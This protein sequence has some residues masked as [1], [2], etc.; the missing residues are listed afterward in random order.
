[1]DSVPNDL[2]VTTPAPKNFQCACNL[3]CRKNCAR[4]RPDPPSSDSNPPLDGP[5]KVFGPDVDLGVWVGR[6]PSIRTKELW[7]WLARGFPSITATLHR[8]GLRG[9]TFTFRPSRHGASA[10]HLLT[11]GL[12]HR[13]R[14]GL[15]GEARV[16]TSSSS[17]CLQH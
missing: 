3:A 1:M 5:I 11:A 2:C 17:R 8:V 4:L 9:L 15:P 14:G 16:S 7:A 10:L 12:T 6:Y 13:L